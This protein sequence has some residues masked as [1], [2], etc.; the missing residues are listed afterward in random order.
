MNSNTQTSLSTVLAASAA[1]LCALA[2]GCK[3]D[4]GSQELLERELRCQED[5]I[6]Q[7]EDEL[8]EMGRALESSRRENQSIKKEIAGGDR[9][10]GSTAVTAPPAIEAPSLEAPKFEFVP[11]LKSTEPL[12][13]APKL[14]DEPLDEAPRFESPKPSGPS[15]GS[16]EPGLLLQ[17][18]SKS[19]RLTGEASRITRLALN[20]Q[21]TGGWNIDGKQGDEGILVS[22]EPRD[23]QNKLVEATGDVSIVL[24]DPAQT[25]AAARVARWDFAA[26]EAALK[27][28]KGPL[29]RGM[30]FELPWPSNPP[31]S[32]DLRLFVRLAT[33]DGRKV[34]ADAKIRVTLRDGWSAKTAPHH[35]P[36]PTSAAEPEPRP[37]SR[38]VARP[39]RGKSS[40]WAPNR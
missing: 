37:A 5:R 24:L 22:F 6:Y 17:Q 14:H 27:F 18:A 40:G 21:L 36:T 11:K 39:R 12:E 15:A 4:G 7:L 28:R 35:E 9:G 30:Q 20:R 2:P 32:R 3:S 31:T 16:K 13:A 8:D 10:P 34:E 19:V 23:A 33:P 25:G 1:L 29:G 26:D 38:L